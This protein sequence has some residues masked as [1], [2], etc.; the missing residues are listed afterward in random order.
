MNVGGGN[1]TGL[2]F[3]FFSTT[4]WMDVIWMDGLINVM[5]MSCTW[6]WWKGICSFG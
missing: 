2:D 6:A 3:F 1:E 4:I 5:H